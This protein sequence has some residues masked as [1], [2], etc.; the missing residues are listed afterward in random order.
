MRRD[1]RRTMGGQ[2][3]ARRMSEGRIATS[4]CRWTIFN[5]SALRYL[6]S[7]QSELQTNGVYLRLTGVLQLLDLRVR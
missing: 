5:K 1:E 7:E 2:R 4:R 6:H 3:G